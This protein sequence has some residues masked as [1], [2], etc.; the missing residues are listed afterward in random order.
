MAGR[1]RS[2]V[3]KAALKFAVE[4]AAIEFGTTS[5][6][7]RKALNKASIRADADGLFTTAQIVTALF[8]EMHQEKLKTQREL[9]RKHALANAVV[10]AGLLDRAEL[11]KTF[12]TLA[13]AIS[14]RIMSATELPRSVR[15]DVLRDIASWPLALEDVKARQSR[16]P[17]RRNGARRDDDD[18]DS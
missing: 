10:E 16:L 9:T 2:N 1:T 17:R 3:P 5:Q 12:A 15:E 8:G 18:D 11:A 4:R 7:L 13:D 6:T 14:S